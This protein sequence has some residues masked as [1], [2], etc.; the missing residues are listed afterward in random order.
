MPTRHASARPTRVLAVLP[1]PRFTGLA[2]LDGT[3]IIPGGFASWNLR[4]GKNQRGT[5]TRASQEAHCSVIALPSYR[6]RHRDSQSQVGRNGGDAHDPGG[7]R[8]R[9]RA[10]RCAP[11]RDRISQASSGSPRRKCEERSCP[12]A[13]PRILSKA[14]YVEK[15]RKFF[16]VPLPRILGPGTGSARTWASCAAFGRRHFQRPRHSA[17]TPGPR[18]S[19]SKPATCIP[20]KTY[21]QPDL[22]ESFGVL[23]I[24]LAAPAALALSPAPSSRRLLDSPG[25]VIRLAAVLYSRTRPRHR[26]RK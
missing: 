23:K 16:Q 3:G 7:S 25:I 24:T 18:F 8:A 5:H 26:R 6:R 20:K 14:G 13:R 12:A 1:A 10:S 11:V 17:W 2:V 19:P 21:D 4:V 22:I 15:G 9:E